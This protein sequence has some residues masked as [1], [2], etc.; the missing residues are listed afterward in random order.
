MGDGQSNGLARAGGTQLAAYGWEVLRG[1]GGSADAH[2]VG[3]DFG[4]QAF[5]RPA[6]ALEFAGLHVRLAVATPKAIR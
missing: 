2:F 5:R 4:L 6:E 1:Y 3:D